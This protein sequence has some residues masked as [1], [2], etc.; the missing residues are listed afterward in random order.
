MA[1]IRCNKPG[2]VAPNA[3]TVGTYSASMDTGNVHTYSVTAG[4]FYI[5]YF[6]G[7]VG[8]TSTVTNGTETITNTLG[9]NGPVIIKAQGNSIGFTGGLYIQVAEV[10]VS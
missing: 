3:L 6:T 1:L 5:L 7:S 2:Q 10:T 8:N 4:H 9:T